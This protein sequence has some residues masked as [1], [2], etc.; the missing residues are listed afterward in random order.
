MAVFKQTNL[1]GGLLREELW[2]RT[3]LPRYPSFVRR[4]ENFYVTPTGQLSNRPGTTRLEVTPGNAAARLV[5]FIFSEGQSYFLVFTPLSVRIYKGGQRTGYDLT[6]TYTSTDIWDLRFVQSGDVL[7]IA[8]PDKPVRQITRTTDVTPWTIADVSFVRSVVAPTGLTCVTVNQVG[9][10]QHTPK[11]WGWKVT[12]WNADQDEEGPPSAVLL[13]PGDGKV[14]ISEDLPATISW[15]AVAGSTRYSIYRGRN[16]LYG[17]VGDAI[18]QTQFRDDGQ[19]PVLSEGP[20]TNRDPFATER[21][22]V[23]TFYQQRLVFANTTNGPADVYLSQ[24]AAF[25]N[26]DYGEP[27]AEDDAV[28]FSVA[29]PQYEE[30]RNAATVHDQLLLFTN[31]TEWAV[32]G[33]DGAPLTAT[34]MAD[35]R[36]QSRWGSSWLDLLQIGRNILYQ[37]DGGYPIRLMFWTQNG[38]DSKDICLLSGSTETGAIEGWCYQRRPHRICW[39]YDVYGRLYSITLDPETDVVAWAEHPMVG[40]RVVSLVCIPEGDE[41]VVYMVVARTLG[42]PAAGIQYVLERLDGRQDDFPPAI[43]NNFLDGAV[44][45]DGTNTSETNTL[46]ITKA[47]GGTIALGDQVTVETAEDSFAADDVG[48][49]VVIRPRE[50]SNRI[51]LDITAYTTARQVTCTVSTESSLVDIADWTTN[52]PAAAPWSAPPDDRNNDFYP[53]NRADWAFARTQFSVSDSLANIGTIWGKIDGQVRSGL[54]VAAGIITT[55]IPVV[56]AS[57]GSAYIQVIETLD[58]AFPPGADG[59]DPTLNIREVV[60][61][62]LEIAKTSAGFQLGSDPDGGL[63]VW[64]PEPG[65]EG[66]EGNETYSRIAYLPVESIF[67]RSGRACVVNTNPLPVT[68]SSIIREVDFGG[69]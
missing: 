54:I 59:K 9:D 69:T 21:P 50:M 53:V 11:E 29:S 39:A 33:S 13:P 56:F 41:D 26:F 46:R 47:G 48:D 61:V 2:G 28:D 51:L 37:M 67:D 32:T 45:F 58:L 68:V 44:H 20:P 24:S 14:A 19:T 34:D 18:G 55:D 64:A 60:K 12:A 66:F 62:G 10:Q 17:Y 42:T 40:A 8:C 52:P 49:R 23:V 4:L 38:W 7:F 35:I 31:G 65:E 15:S 30:I 3:D 25:K 5:P 27:A 63:T 36:P 6:T 43:T 57:F 1:S 22:Q 16:G